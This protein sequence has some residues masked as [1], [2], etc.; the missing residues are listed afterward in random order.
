LDRSDLTKGYQ[1]SSDLP[2]KKQQFP[3]MN[4][5]MKEYGGFSGLHVSRTLDQYYYETLDDT[6][7]RDRDQVVYR[8]TERKH[9]KVPEQPGQG[10]NITLTEKEIARKRQEVRGRQPTSAQKD[11]EQ[12]Q[13]AFLS[14]RTMSSIRCE[15]QQQ[16]IVDG[17]VH[18]TS[19]YDEN[20]TDRSRQIKILMVNQLWLWKIDERRC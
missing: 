5:L 14:A 20:Q 2:G 11:K 1:G 8:Y 19:R 16:P 12:A 4:S 18:Q 6:S 15:N 13:L 10:K 9:P 3:K 17:N 7:A